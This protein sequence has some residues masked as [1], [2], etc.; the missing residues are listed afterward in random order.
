MAERKDTLVYNHGSE[1]RLNQLHEKLDHTVQNRKWTAAEDLQPDVEDLTTHVKETRARG[2]QAMNIL[3]ESNFCLKMSEN[4]K[5]WK[6]CAIWE[7]IYSVCRQILYF[8]LKSLKKEVKDYKE[9]KKSLNK[10]RKAV[11]SCS[12]EGRN[13]GT[14]E[15]VQGNRFTVESTLSDHR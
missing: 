9:R 14:E 1:D 7:D 5:D 15:D 11:T 8:H 3:K 10:K 13:G 12:Q 6:S 4:A 2:D